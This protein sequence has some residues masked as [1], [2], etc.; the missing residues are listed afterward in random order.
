MYGQTE[1]NSSTYYWVTQLPVDDTEKLP[2]GKALP[3]FE[4]FALDENGNRVQKAGEKG[5]LYVRASTVAWGYWDELEKTENAF[6]RNPLRSNVTERVYKTGDLVRLDLNGNYVF[7]GRKDHMI[8]SR[9]YRIEIG[10]VETVLCTHP[11][12]KNAVVLPIPDELIGNR[13]TAIVVPSSPNKISQDDVLRHCFVQLPKYMIPETIEFR[14]LITDDV[15]WKSGSD[16]A[17]KFI[18]LFD[19]LEFHDSFWGTFL[20]VSKI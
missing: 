7:I 9:G 4:V 17:K 6:V 10:E 15:I 16:E 20:M 18:K 11:E 19:E 8:K 1:A 14:E 13:L 2:I 5:K 12:I 3:N